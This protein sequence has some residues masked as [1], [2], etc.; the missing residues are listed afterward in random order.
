[1]GDR[2]AK[3]ERVI[4][5]ALD[6][7]AACFDGPRRLSIIIVKPGDAAHEHSIVEHGLEY[8]DF[9]QHGDHLGHALAAALVAVSE[10]P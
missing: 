8:P 1:V 6:R 7:I 2:M 3:L 10:A 9:A 5:A 4:G